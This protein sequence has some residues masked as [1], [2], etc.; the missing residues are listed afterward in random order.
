[1]I[2]A[3]DR[4]VVCAGHQRRAEELADQTFEVVV[5]LAKGLTH[6]L[7]LRVVDGARAR[8][9]KLAQLLRPSRREARVLRDRGSQVS[10]A[11]ASEVHFVEA[12]LRLLLLRR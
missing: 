9:R 4:H 3:C 7:E 1:M 8:V 2:A 5:A 11:G 6:A 10:D 12:E